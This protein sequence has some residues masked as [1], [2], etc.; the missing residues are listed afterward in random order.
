MEDLVVAARRA[1]HDQSAARPER[2]DRLGPG[3][4]GIEDEVEARAARRRGARGARPVGIGIRDTAAGTERAGMI[5]RLRG[6]VGH[7]DG[8]PDGAGEHDGER[9]HA[10]PGAEDQD[11]LPGAQPTPPQQRTVD[12]DP[13][14]RQRGG[15]VPGP[16]VGPG[17]E[18]IRRHENG[19]G[20][21]PPAVVAEDLPARARRGDLV[22]PPQG[23]HDHDLLAGVRAHP[24]PIGARHVRQRRAVEPLPDENVMPV[25]RAGAQIDPNHPVRRTRLRDILGDKD[26]GAAVGAHEGGIHGGPPFGLTINLACP[27]LELEHVVGT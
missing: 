4:D 13:D 20:E 21:S 6:A 12:G 24:G 16:P 18:A 2:G 1:Q 19:F 11:V 14:E 27:R 17:D 25:E 15:L 23:R 7:P 3:A 8:R 26:I 22:A 9:G 5:E 10:A